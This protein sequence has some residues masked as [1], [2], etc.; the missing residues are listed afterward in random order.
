MLASELETCEMGAN[1]EI[2][3]QGSLAEAFFIVVAG[4]LALRRTRTRADGTEELVEEY[5]LQAPSHVGSHSLDYSPE[6][7]DGAGG[8]G[9]AGDLLASVLSS[10]SRVSRSPTRPQQVGS[11]GG[12]SF[13]HRSPTAK[14]GPRKGPP[15]ARR[16]PPPIW[17]ETIVTDSA[18]AMTRLLWISRER[19]AELLGGHLPDIIRRNAIDCAFAKV[20]ITTARAPPREERPATALLE[21][22]HTCLMPS[23]SVLS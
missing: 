11:A 17:Q 15:V 13:E 16:K 23:P 5:R 22:P 6:Q 1:E 10:P 2:A 19:F 18:Y 14:G 3:C 21:A 4:G 12:S 9:G 20:W 8:A 7:G